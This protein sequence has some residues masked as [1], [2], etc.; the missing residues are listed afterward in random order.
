MRVS[1]NQSVHNGTENVHVHKRHSKAKEREKYKKYSDIYN[2]K[3]N[4][5]VST[6][7]Y[8][9]ET[10]KNPLVSKCSIFS[11]ADVWTSE[12]LLGKKNTASER[13]SAIGNCFQKR[14]ELENK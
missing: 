13:T 3:K 12:T 5:N 2:T 10:I 8:N 9:Y 4:R 7:V 1:Y 14:K 6:N 11:F